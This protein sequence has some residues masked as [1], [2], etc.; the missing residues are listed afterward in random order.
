MI[1]IVGL[2]LI[3]LAVLA[4]LI[5]FFIVVKALFPNRVERA[6]YHAHST[7]GKTFM[8]GLVNFVFFAAVAL[9]FFGLA[10]AVG[11]QLL[12]MLALLI[13]VIPALGIVIGLGGIVVM[14][15]ERLAPEMVDHRRTG[16]GALALSLAC[17]LP[18]VGWFGLFPYL[19]LL[20][21]GASILSLFRRRVEA[22]QEDE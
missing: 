7:P 9:A 2:I 22:D 19:C 10:D 16:L 18:F 1:E 5:A 11:V 15:G 21:L 12:Q 13:L 4:S 8:V 20:A 17:A 14:T 3:V 6:R